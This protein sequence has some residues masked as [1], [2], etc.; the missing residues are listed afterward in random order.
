[1][2]EPPL[3]DIRNATLYRG[4][5]RV[6]DDL[7]VTIRQ[8][9]QVAVIGPNGAGKTTLLKV[10]NREIYPVVKD[11][12]WVRIL[13]S[14]T[15][16][17]WELRA[18]IGIVS[19]DLQSR[20]EP[21]TTG[22]DVVVSGFFSSIGTRGLLAERVTAGNRDRARAVMT[23]L[24][25]ADLAGVALGRMSTGQQR[26]CLLARALVHDPATLILD[27]PTAGLDLAASF[28]Y[29]A[30]I[31]RLIADGRN[32]ILVTHHLNEIP[33]DIDRVILLRAGKI[34]ADGNKARVLNESNLSAAY[35]VPVRLR[36][37]SGYY[38]PF[39]REASG[40]GENPAA[41]TA[42]PTGREKRRR[43]G[44]T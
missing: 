16:N 31:R 24:G 7:S 8:H 35:G 40:S 6:F 15:W 28:D 34:L 33:P 41:K 39:P 10:L 42:L 38:L 1:M 44:K 30:R 21:R 13:G 5:T 17:V 11:G 27:E 20:Y 18:R 22:L 29:L 26:R 19:D 36:T 14:E 32:L 43:P 23:E 37:E 3:I 2:S 4:S 12:S 9:E 25:V